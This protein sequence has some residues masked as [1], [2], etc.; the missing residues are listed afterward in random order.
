MP[1]RPIRLS[2]ASVY[3]KSSVYLATCG[4]YHALCPSLS[5]LC[6]PP[7]QIADKNNEIAA[8]WWYNSVKN[9][10]SIRYTLQQRRISGTLPFDASL[11][12]QR[13]DCRMGRLNATGCVVRMAVDPISLSTNSSLATQSLKHYCLGHHKHR[14]T[15]CLTL[16]R[17]RTPEGMYANV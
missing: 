11:L 8:L 17:L 16:A 3:F 13:C 1:D 7:L 2:I 9:V 5:W 12:R 14:R 4:A 10:T 6:A 15:R